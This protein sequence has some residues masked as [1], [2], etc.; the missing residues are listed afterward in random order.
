[1]SK[2]IVP[3]NQNTG[4]PAVPDY[5]RVE[6]DTSAD[7]LKGYVRPPRIKV[8]QS[9]TDQ[10]LREDFGVGS[11]I[12]LPQNI[13]ILEMP[14]DKKGNPLVDTAV[15][16]IFTPLFFFPEFCVWNP[17]E[18]KGNVP[19][20][21]DRSFDPNSDIARRARDFK[22]RTMPYPGKENLEIKFVEHLN[23]IVAVH[24]IEDACV[25]SFSR[26]EFSA[27]QKFAVQSRILGWTEV[28]CIYQDAVAMWLSF[29]WWGVCC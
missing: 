20:I 2:D 7:S 22:A 9:L 25:L 21:R 10:K 29:V 8:I 3:V 12:L 27:G 19:A 13:C 5:L 16:F 11:V 15:P 18:E 4:L 23:F 6:G 14:R 24:G 26:A 28:R 1:M 17:L